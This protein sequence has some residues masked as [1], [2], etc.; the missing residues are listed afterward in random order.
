MT[1]NT[2]NTFTPDNVEM[3]Q[4]LNAGDF[5]LGDNYQE[6]L[7]ND[8]AYSSLVTRLGKPITMGPQLTKKFNFQ[9]EGYGAYWVNETE[10]IRTSK[11]KW[12]TATMTAH[13]LGLI[14][15]VSKE[16]L[17]FGPQDFWGKAR[18]LMTSAIQE[19]IDE[20]VLLGI[21]TPGAGNVSIKGSAEKNGHAIVGPINYENMQALQD[22]VFDANAKY[23]V[24][25]MISRRSNRSALS[26]AFQT[27]G[28]TNAIIDRPYVKG[29]DGGSYDGITVVDSKLQSFPAK[30]IIAGDW[31]N[32]Y[33]A[34]PRGFEFSLS[35]SAQLSTIENADGSPVNLFEQDMVA[36][37]VT[38][39]FG[40]LLVRDDAFSILEP[41]VS[42]EN[43]PVIGID[44]MSEKLKAKN[45]TF[46]NHARLNGETTNVVAFNSQEKSGTFLKPTWNV[47]LGKATDLKYEVNEDGSLFLITGK[48]SG[49]V[50]VTA[51][52]AGVASEAVSLFVGSATPD[53]VAAA[54]PTAG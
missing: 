45:G 29:T 32:L 25:A 48:E 5:G 49:E 18:P 36:L 8:L 39:Y 47:D 38:F 35:D 13:K 15:P 34:V 44:M 42:A 54:A 31:N 21:D 1:V 43:K 27:I 6:L 3:L 4:K 12:A 37:K 23:D 30:T 20:A 7:L 41:A 24:N 16:W 11:G 14:I 50:K 22:V 33:Y 9:T 26:N 19:K 17:N 53:D 51:T 52:A 40:Y 10:K 46:Y 2:P 28:G